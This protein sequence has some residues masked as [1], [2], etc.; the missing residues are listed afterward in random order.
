M[1]GRQNAMA[2]CDGDW[3]SMKCRIAVI[4]VIGGIVVAVGAVVVVVAVVIAVAVAAVCRTGVGG[5]GGVAVVLGNSVIQP[6]V[7]ASTNL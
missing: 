4:V 2:N 5:G 6:R 7:A 3:F 1:D